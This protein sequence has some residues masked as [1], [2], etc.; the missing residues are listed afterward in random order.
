VGT[1]G[2]RG[3]GPGEFSTAHNIAVDKM[4]RV[5]VADRSNGRL[6]VFDTNGNFL[7]EVIVNVATPKVQ[8]LMGHQYPP[9]ED[10]KPGSNFAYRPG[11]PDALCIP[12]DNPNVMFIGDL[13]PGRVYKIDMEGKVLG[14]FGHVGKLPGEMGGIHGL[15]CPSENLIY[16]AEFENWRTQK[17]VLH[18]EKAKTSSGDKGTATTAKK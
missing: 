1:W 17:F 10:A 5:W 4:D 3:F 8:P 11:T 16:T 6:Q 13:Y 12:P 14:Y 7:K 15:A 18:P 9:R 2:K